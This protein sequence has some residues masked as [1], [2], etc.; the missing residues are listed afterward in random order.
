MKNRHSLDRIESPLFFTEIKV[1]PLTHLDSFS[2]PDAK[3]RLLSVDFIITIA[4]ILSVQRNNRYM[5]NG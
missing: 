1:S 5:P 4:D 2:N 3:D